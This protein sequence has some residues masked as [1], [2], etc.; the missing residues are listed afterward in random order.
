MQAPTALNLAANGFISLWRHAWERSSR[1]VRPA[2][3]GPLGLAPLR[4]RRLRKRSAPKRVRPQLLYANA[5]MKA[6]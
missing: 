3:R 5:Q 4:R 2:G 6:H 1:P